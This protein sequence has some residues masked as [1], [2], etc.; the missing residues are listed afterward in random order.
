MWD[1]AETNKS[2]KSITLPS[3]TLKQETPNLALGK[4]APFDAPHTK[5]ILKSRTM[6]MPP[7]RILQCYVH[8]ALRTNLNEIKKREEKEREVK[9]EKYKVQ[10]EAMRQ[11]MHD[12]REI[13][14]RSDSFRQTRNKNYSNRND[15]SKARWDSTHKTII[16][17]NRP[18]T[19]KK[20]KGCEIPNANV[21][22]SEESR[23]YSIRRNNEKLERR[24]FILEE[25]RK[26]PPPPP[27]LPQPIPCEVV[28]MVKSKMPR[29]RVNKRFH[30]WDSP[31][32]FS[33]GHRCRSSSAFVMTVPVSPLRSTSDFENDDE[34]VLV[35]CATVILSEYSKQSEK[36]HFKDVHSLTERGC[37]PHIDIWEDQESI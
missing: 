26:N 3:M 4:R 11:R 15:A 35:S 31:P 37:A 30:P 9:M 25:I 36:K 1:I 27:P 32:D 22:D 7:E 2:S 10:I 19:D 23:F 14:T 33:H 12:Q 18:P 29:K 21:V 17:E 8:P 6:L 5:Q 28:L 24:K 20:E 34:F 13:K 16:T